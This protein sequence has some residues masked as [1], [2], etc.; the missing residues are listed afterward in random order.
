MIYILKGCWELSV[1]I[2]CFIFLFFAIFIII[3]IKGI[4]SL[5]KPKK[6]MEN[7]KCSICK[8]TKDTK[9]SFAD[10]CRCAT[11]AAYGSSSSSNSDSSSSFVPPSTDY[12]TSS[13]GPPD[14]SS[15]SNDFDFGGGSFDGGGSGGDW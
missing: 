5:F 1:G 8:K 11:Y 13:D 15:S 6:R 4:I 9:A 2:T 12:F 3:V 7:L 14:S 10:R